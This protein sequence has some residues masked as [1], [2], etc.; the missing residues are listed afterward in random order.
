MLS[1]QQV[2]QAL[3]L[4]M[5][6]G[7]SKTC[8]CSSGT[9]IHVRT[10]GADPAIMGGTEVMGAA[11]W[12]VS[13]GDATPLHGVVVQRAGAAKQ[14]AVVLEDWILQHV[15]DADVRRQR[16]QVLRGMRQGFAYQHV[17]KLQEL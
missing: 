8:G 6:A 16:V 15:H 12:D 9:G 2:L 5:A 13:D 3:Q 17:Q 11:V 14:V 7:G 10:V 4:L 1:Q